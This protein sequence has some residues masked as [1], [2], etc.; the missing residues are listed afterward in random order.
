MSALALAFVIFNSMPAVCGDVNQRPSAK[1]DPCLGTHR[2]MY[3]VSQK[4]VSNQKVEE[5]RPTLK[6]YFTYWVVR[7]ILRRSEDYSIFR[8]I[9]NL[10]IGSEREVQVWS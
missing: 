2:H 8:N 10:S 7:A 9:T 4:R 5:N 1:S 6:F 3:R